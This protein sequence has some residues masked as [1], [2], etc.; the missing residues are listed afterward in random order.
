[1]QQA[2][3]Q[4]MPISEIVSHIWCSGRITRNHR[5]GLMSALLEGWL[6]P[7]EYNAIDRL[8]H[9]VRRGWLKM[10]D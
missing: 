3:V 6:T 8:F 10:V 7:E 5:Y 9:A 2:L 1:M 4:S